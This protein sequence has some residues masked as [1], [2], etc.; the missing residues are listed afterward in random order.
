MFSELEQA[1]KNYLQIVEEK[2]RLDEEERGYNND[3]SE[4]A[5]EQMTKAK[6]LSKSTE[7]RKDKISEKE[8][9]SYKLKDSKEKAREKQRKFDQERIASNKIRREKD[10]NEIKKTTLK[11]ELDMLN[12][13]LEKEEKFVLENKK[14]MDKCM[15][16]RD[17]LN[18]D[19]VNAEGQARQKVSEKQTLGN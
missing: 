7:Q 8:R 11:Q 13:N 2:K 9:E 10:D 5:K 14:D 15:R 3:L 1:K 4:I 17:L 6:E 12:G 19:V 18:K 16:D